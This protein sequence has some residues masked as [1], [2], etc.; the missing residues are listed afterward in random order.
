MTSG[1]RLACRERRQPRKSYGY[2]VAKPV[3]IRHRGIS[4]FADRGLVGARGL[5]V[6][7]VFQMIFMKVVC[8]T[9][10]IPL[11]LSV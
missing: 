8:L 5:S 7:V 9:G 10:A 1:S 6:D 4:I 11:L 3:R 2:P